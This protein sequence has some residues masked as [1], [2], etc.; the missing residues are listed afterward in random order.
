MSESVTSGWRDEHG[1]VH[2]CEGNDNTPSLFTYCGQSIIA[3]TDI[4]DDDPV[5]CLTC[6]VEGEDIF[7]RLNRRIVTAMQIPH[8]FLGISK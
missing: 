5:T 2:T 6:L 7:T 8:E 1:V 3:M 4:A